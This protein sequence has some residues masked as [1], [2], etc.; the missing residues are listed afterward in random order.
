MKSW[1][2]NLSSKISFITL[3]FFFFFFYNI[4]DSL[5]W[6][7]ILVAFLLTHYRDISFYYNVAA[8]FTQH[9]VRN[10][11]HNF[12]ILKRIR[13][14]TDLKT[15]TSVI[16]KRFILCH[17]PT[18]KSNSL[19]VERLA[20]YPWITGSSNPVGNFI[21]NIALYESLSLKSLVMQFRI[22]FT[23]QVHSQEIVSQKHATKDF[24]NYK[25]L[26]CLEK[27]GGMRMFITLRI[28]RGGSELLTA[29]TDFLLI[30]VIFDSN[31]WHFITADL[32]MNLQAWLH[33]CSSC[34]SWVM[35]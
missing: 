18:N 24:F 8:I 31:W 35:L 3:F 19:V 5:I 29:T 33:L 13:L 9:L 15:K 16:N 1:H 7:N 32:A 14:R 11:S 25:T 21:F 34:G 26:N 20:H 22:F 4:W 23:D 2:F 17:A 6:C 28:V 30:L 10:C 12:E 27:N